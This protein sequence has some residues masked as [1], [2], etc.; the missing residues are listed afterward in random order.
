MTA[1]RRARGGRRNGVYHFPGRL[2]SVCPRCEAPRGHRCVK[3]MGDQVV[4]MVNTHKERRTKR[5]AR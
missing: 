3:K 1:A 2:A 5:G 4:P